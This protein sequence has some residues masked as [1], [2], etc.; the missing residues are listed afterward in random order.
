MDT[1]NNFFPMD[2]GGMPMQT[3]TTGLPN[4]IPNPQQQSGGPQATNTNPFGQNIFMAVG[5]APYTRN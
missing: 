5:A 3:D 1:T 4:D 2:L